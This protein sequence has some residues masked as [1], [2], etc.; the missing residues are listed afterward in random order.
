[1]SI[2]ESLHDTRKVEVALEV[3]VKFR[4]VFRIMS[5]IYTA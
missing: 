3:V 4:G 1:M 5:N 2:M